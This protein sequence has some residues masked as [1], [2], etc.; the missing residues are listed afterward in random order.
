[1]REPYFVPESKPVDDIL[2]EFREHGVHLAIVIDE[3]GGTFGLLTMEDLLEEIVGE[4]HDE[5]DVEEPEFEATPEGDVLI[6]G[7]A[8]ISEVNERFGLEI[9]DEDFDTIGGYIFGVLGRVAEPGDVVETAGE[10]VFTV[11]EM[12][13][14]RVVLIRLHGAGAVAREI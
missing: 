6:D 5:Y 11:E 10:R 12:E 8:A 4:I 2:G 13:D 14:R 3:F 9:P 1:M 7:G